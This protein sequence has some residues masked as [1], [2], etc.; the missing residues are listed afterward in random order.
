MNGPTALD[1][2]VCAPLDTWKIH[3]QFYR[4]PRFHTYPHL[5][6][7]GY[8]ATVM[9]VEAGSANAELQ[10]VR[11]DIARCF[12]R[13]DCHLLPHPGQRVAESAEFKGS[14]ADM[15]PD[16]VAAMREYVPGVFAPENLVPKMFL[17]QRVTC[18]MLLTYIEVRPSS[19]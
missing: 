5:G 12:G 14:V 18:K 10:S 11:E 4:T 8:L 7:G 17:G 13:V 1:R 15:R 9:E 2:K 3:A 16:F 6:G 19:R